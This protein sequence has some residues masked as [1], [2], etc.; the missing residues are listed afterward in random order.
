M[1]AAGASEMAPA[2]KATG[3]H[4]AMYVIPVLM[5][6]CSGSLFGAASTVGADMRR[7]RESMGSAPGELVSQPAR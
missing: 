5:V 3:L 2:F 4:T 1:A 6:L 7:L